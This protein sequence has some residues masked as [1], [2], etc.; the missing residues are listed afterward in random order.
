MRTNLLSLFFHSLQMIGISCAPV[1]WR[2]V[3]RHS[4]LK[5]RPS[6]LIIS[7]QYG[8][9]ALS[10]K[11]TL[12]R[13]RGDLSLHWTDSGNGAP[14]YLFRIRWNNI[15]FGSKNQKYP[16]IAS[17]KGC[18]A[19]GFPV[20]FASCCLTTQSVLSQKCRLSSGKL[21]LYEIYAICCRALNH[22]PIRF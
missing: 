1:S 7:H 15:S 21:R 16:S 4:A 2:R 10:P 5:W 14:W 13:P 9:R 3:L 6:V 17:Q 20:R 11:P 22:H 8:Q 18:L 12:P 19:T